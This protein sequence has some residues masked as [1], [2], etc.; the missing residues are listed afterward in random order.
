MANNSF[1]REL[2]S[3]VSPFNYRESISCL[4]TDDFMTV[5]RFK[6][7]ELSQLFVIDHSKCIIQGEINND[8]LFET[9]GYFSDELSESVRT[10]IIEW[11]ESGKKYMKMW[12]LNSL[13]TDI[14]AYKS[15]PWRYVAS[16]ITEMNC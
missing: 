6:E 15:W 9:F 11:I 12:E 10:D 8:H 13:N 3:L 4:D 14:E 2:Y 7:H 5:R 1:A 16:F